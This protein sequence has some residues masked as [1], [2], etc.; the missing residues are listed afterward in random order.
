MGIKE[1]KEKGK[2]GRYRSEVK[3]A[4]IEGI[5]IDNYF[6]RKIYE[7]GELVETITEKRKLPEKVKPPH[8]VP[9]PVA[10]A[11]LLLID[12]KNPF[13]K[14]S[15]EVKR[16]ITCWVVHTEKGETFV[17][18]VV[19]GKKVGEGIPAPTDKA[20]SLSGYHEPSWPDP[21]VGYRE[22][23]AYWFNHWGFS[24]WSIFA[25]SKASLGTAISNGEYK[26][27]YALAHGSST[28]FQSQKGIWVTASN[29]SG[30]MG[31][32]GGDGG[33]GGPPVRDGGSPEPGGRPPMWFAFI[34]HCTGMVGTGSGTFSHAFRR[35]QLV[36]TVT[37]GWYNAH[38]NPD[39]WAQSLNWQKK[40]FSKMN[41]GVTWKNAYNYANAVYPECVSMVRF[42]GDINMKLR[43]EGGEEN[44]SLELTSDPSGQDI[45]IDGAHVGV[46][47][48]TVDVTCV[49]HTIQIGSGGG[50]SDHADHSDTGGGPAHRP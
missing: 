28:S 18:D 43:P 32:S 36:N 29:I 49:A 35:G 2:A 47:P 13:W 24:T 11:K 8:I 48:K 17:Y 20:I 30:W 26:N 6:E 40:L 31:G 7:E 16:D 19:T 50:H 41:T 46:T 23:A 4:S 1:I 15:P 45:Y 44:M 27:Y 9:P 39:G 37:M 22:N 34:G 33:G 25:P 21:W 10:E 38:T 14:L 12:H 3:K 5:E 42:V